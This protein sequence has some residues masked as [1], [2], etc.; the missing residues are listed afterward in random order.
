MLRLRGGMFHETSS[1]ADWSSLMA[2]NNTAN[3][4]E[5][6]MVRRDAI[7]GAVASDT[8][9]LHRG[10]PFAEFRR[11]VSRLPRPTPNALEGVCAAS[12]EHLVGER[13]L[14][15]LPETLSETLAQPSSPT[16]AALTPGRA[17]TA[18]PPAEKISSVNVSSAAS[19]EHIIDM[20]LWAARRLCRS[21]WARDHLSRIDPRVVFGVDFSPQGLRVNAA[22]RPTKV[23]PLGAK[24]AAPAELS[25]VLNAAGERAAAIVQPLAFGKA[26]LKPEVVVEKT[27]GCVYSWRQL[28]LADLRWNLQGDI[29]RFLGVPPSDF[30]VELALEQPLEGGDRPLVAGLWPR[31]RSMPLRSTAVGTPAF[32][33]SAVQEI[34]AYLTRWLDQAISGEFVPLPRPMPIPRARPVMMNIGMVNIGGCFYFTH[35]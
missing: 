12:P 18:A 3:E 20:P 9:R 34:T 27:D 28:P 16:G 24:A 2:T 30:H 7:T 17:F 32:S 14:A 15:R 5:V 33:L 6:E 10:M 21:K 23:A 1:R 8:V 4:I 29:A 22:P 25:A 35:G 13:S 26:M 11:L 31:P 19:V